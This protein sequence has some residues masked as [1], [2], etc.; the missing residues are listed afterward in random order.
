MELPSGHH[1]RVEI[2][3]VKKLLGGLLEPSKGLGKPFPKRVVRRR[4]ACFELPRWRDR[5][6]LIA[7]AAHDLDPF[8]HRNANAESK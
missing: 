3:Y 5:H 4:A 6:S 1:V 7:S 2:V 8:F